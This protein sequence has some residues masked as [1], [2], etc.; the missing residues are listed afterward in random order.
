MNCDGRRKIWERLITGNRLD[1]IELQLINGRVDLTAFKVPDP[2]VTREYNTE[3]ANVKQFGNL[4]H[5]HDVHWDGIDF[6]DSRLN[7]LR[8]HGCRIQNCSFDNAE[9][10]DW[11]IWRTHISNCSFRSTDLRRSSLGGVEGGERNLFQN[12][13]FT[14]ADLRQT[15]HESADFVECRFSDTNLAKVDFW[16]TIFLNCVFEGRLDEVI[17]HRQAFRGEKYPPNEMKGVDFRR[18]RFR[19]VEFRGLDMTDVRW[20]EDDDAIVLENYSETLKQVLRTLK[21]RSDTPSMKLAAIIESDLKW[22]G[23]GQ[24]QGLISKRDLNE[25]GGEWAVNEFLKLIG[26]E[27]RI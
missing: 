17:F 22:A 24:K 20:P 10:Q 12:I 26:R 16:G 15:A 9:C 6:S 23:P 19:F 25:V 5:I 14:K 2:L 11:R 1:G 4:I 18:A 13:D 7:S 8:F 27:R 21:T 3:K